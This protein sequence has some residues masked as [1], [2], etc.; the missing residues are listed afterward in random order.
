M[1]SVSLG[2]IRQKPES[3]N[4]SIMHVFC[5]DLCPAVSSRAVR[6]GLE[7]GFQGPGVGFMGHTET[8]E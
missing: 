5:E 8:S 3:F 4:I 7:G 2:M 1:C 6:L